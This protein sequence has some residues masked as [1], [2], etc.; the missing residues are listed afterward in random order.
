MVWNPAS[1]KGTDRSQQWC[2]QFNVMVDD[3]NLLSAMLAGVCD[4]L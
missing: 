2:F 4:L 1:M 3:G